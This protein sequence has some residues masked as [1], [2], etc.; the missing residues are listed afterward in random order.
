MLL[1]PLCS[2]SLICFRRS[3]FGL[4]SLDLAESPDY[5]LIVFS[6]VGSINR[7]VLSIVD[8]SDEFYALSLPG[9]QVKDSHLL[10]DFVS[11]SFFSGLE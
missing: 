9:F 7:Y 2:G 5:F 4:I 3:S 6:G 10:S 8:N 11:S 1:L